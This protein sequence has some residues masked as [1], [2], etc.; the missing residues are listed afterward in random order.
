MTEIKGYENYLIYEDGKV[1]S[2]KR[3]KFLSP[4]PDKDGYLQ[5]NL[6]KNGKSKSYR[7]HRLIGLHFIPNPNNFPCIDH[8]DMSKTNNNLNNL[9]WCSYSTN[10]KN[11]GLMKNNKLK[12]KYIFEF[13]QEVNGKYYYYYKFKITGIIQKCF[14]CNEYNLD[15]VIKYRD[16]FLL[17]N[18]I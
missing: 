17:N 11:K 6:W 15:D 1:Y 7:I 9:R 2:K 12:Q 8:I 16:E 5:V 14:S 4:C 10:N 3:K 18:K 13:D